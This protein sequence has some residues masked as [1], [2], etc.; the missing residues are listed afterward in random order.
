MGMA[1]P[2]PAFRSPRMAVLMPTSRPS[3]S[4][5]APPELPG[6]IDASVCTKS[7]SIR[8]PALKFRCTAET[9]PVVTVCERPNG[10]PIAMS[11]SPG[12]RSS[13]RPI[14]A[15]GSRSFVS[16]FSTARSVEG[17][18]PTTF[19]MISRPSRRPTRKRAP[20]STTW[21]FVRT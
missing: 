1:K 2:M 9:T 5:S 17:S 18:V 6:L 8:S 11:V 13:E 16:S 4:S 14:V 15:N 10:L 19:A 3:M 12:R 21:L 7:K 20:R